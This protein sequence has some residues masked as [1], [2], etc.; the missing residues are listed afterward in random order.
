VLLLRRRGP[1]LHRDELGPSP[2]GPHSSRWSDWSWRP[3]SAQLGGPG[4]GRPTRGRS[5]NRVEGGRSSRRRGVFIGRTRG[6]LSPSARSSSRWRW[7]PAPF[8]GSC[9]TSPVWSASSTWTGRREWEQ[10]V[11]AQA[12]VLEDHGVI[13]SLR[14]S[15]RLTRGHWWR[16]FGSGRMRGGRLALASWTSTKPVHRRELGRLVPCPGRV[17]NAKP[18]SPA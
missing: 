9:S 8:N 18:R 3:R 5:G 16:T 11:F 2:S 13:G 6:R 17:S 15:A 1:R 14:A 4:R 10:P 7:P 12:C